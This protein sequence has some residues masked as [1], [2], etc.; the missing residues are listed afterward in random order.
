MLSDP[1]KEIGDLCLWWGIPFQTSMLEFK[2]PF[3][4]FLE[5]LLPRTI[6]FA[7]GVIAIGGSDSVY[8][9]SG[10]PSSLSGYPGYPKSELLR[11][12]ED[13]EKPDADSH[14]YA[15]GYSE[16]KD[17]A[18]YPNTFS[19]FSTLQ[20]T[21]TIVSTIQ[22]HRSLSNDEILRVEEEVGLL[23]IKSLGSRVSGLRD[24]LLSRTWYGFNLDETLHEFDR[25]VDGATTLLT[26][27]RGQHVHFPRL[28]MRIE[29]AITDPVERGRQQISEFFRSNV[30]TEQYPNAEASDTLAKDYP[31]FLGPSLEI[32]YGALSLFTSLKRM[33]KKIAI[34]TTGSRHLR[35][36]MLQELGLWDLVDSLETSNG[37]GFACLFQDAFEYFNDNAIYIGGS[38]DDISAARAQGVYCIHY[39]E[40][41]NISLQ[42]GSIIS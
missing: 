42:S 36:W 40:A 17:V 7:G 6:T 15:S 11:L 12:D 31:R 37:N 24:T 9:D 32:K 33:G 27:R 10:Y 4:T 20:A 35:V 38:L 19:P 23:Y 30:K 41:E 39:S 1:A 2:Q 34:F 25:M 14:S 29:S 22:S 13:R 26:P 3:R 5:N 18:A 16:V 28:K 21:D 8:N